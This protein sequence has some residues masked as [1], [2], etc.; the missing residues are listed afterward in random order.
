MEEVY[1]NT[2]ITFLPYWSGAAWGETGL[3]RKELGVQDHH[4]QI[5]RATAGSNVWLNY[6]NIKVCNSFIHMYTCLSWTF[7][8]WELSVA[9]FISIN[10]KGECECYCTHLLFVAKQS[11]C[12][13]HQNFSNVCW[14]NVLL[15]MHFSSVNCSKKGSKILFP[16][17]QEY[18]WLEWY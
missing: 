2:G 18:L 17:L 16:I 3:I 10:C 1:L 14:W 6:W 4:I 12:S 15:E 9:W 7:K 13:L 11:P 8:T 5:P